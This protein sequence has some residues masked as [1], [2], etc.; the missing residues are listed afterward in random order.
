MKTR[1]MAVILMALLS[2]TVSV[3]S[4]NVQAKRFGGGGKSIGRSFQV[5][6]KPQRPSSPGWERGKATDSRGFSQPANSGAP[7][8][9]GGLLGGLAGGLLGGL[10]V[11]GLLSSLFGGGAFQGLQIADMVI[12]AL[13]AFVLFKLFKRMARSRMA[14]A[15]PAMAAPA[16]TYDAQSA[17]PWPTQAPQPA[18]GAQPDTVSPDVPMNLPANFDVERFVQTSL[19]HYRTVQKAWDRADMATLRDYLSPALFDHF[20]QERTALQGSQQTEILYL[21]ADLVRADSTDAYAHV[22]LRFTGR[23]RNGVEQTEEDIN[24]IWHLERDMNSSTGAWRVIGI[25]H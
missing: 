7:G 2:V 20:E 18:V 5:A 12:M 23:C 16:A 25:G 1:P 14:S 22:S 24:D 10:L 9:K 21:D 6:P 4:I 3:A 11:G 15:E 13:I 8:K 19:E 17:R